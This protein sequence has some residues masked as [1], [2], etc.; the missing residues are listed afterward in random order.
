MGVEHDGHG[1]VLPMCESRAWTFFPQ[2]GQITLIVMP[3]LAGLSD[4]ARFKL[5]VSLARLTWLEYSFT[6]RSASRVDLVDQ[7][8]Y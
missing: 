2:P 8:V 7:I 3:Y 4:L 1:N 5:R 6:R